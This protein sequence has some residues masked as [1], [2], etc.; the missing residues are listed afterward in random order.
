MKV[1]IK[2]TR[3]IGKLIFKGCWA[4]VKWT[5][6]GKPTEEQKTDE[7]GTPLWRVKALLGDEV[8]RVSVPVV[9]SPGERLND[10]DEIVF[11][12]FVIESHENK[13]RP[14]RWEKLTAEK[15]VVAKKGTE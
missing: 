5:K 14:E 2:D 10:G 8:I 13:G 1:K 6:D 4:D 7:S 15:I 9:K 3:E 12:G 11:C